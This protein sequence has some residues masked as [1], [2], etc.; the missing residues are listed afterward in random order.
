M[1][2]VEVKYRTNTRHGQPQEAVNHRK[3]RTI[4]KVANYYCLT[5]GM[6]E[7][8]ACRFDVVAILGDKVTLLRNAFEYQC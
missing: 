3:Q 2:F 8:T 4:C 6:Q 5:H 1:V 7:G